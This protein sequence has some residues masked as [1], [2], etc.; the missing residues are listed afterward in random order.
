MMV[1]EADYISTL[2]VGVEGESTIVTW[3]KLVTKKKLAFEGI[4]KM[5]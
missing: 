1:K 4:W 2:G 3:T 5:I